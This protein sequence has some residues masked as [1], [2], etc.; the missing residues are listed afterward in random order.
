MINENENG[1]TVGKMQL[2]VM[3]WGCIC[4]WKYRDNDNY[5]GDVEVEMAPT[6]YRFNYFDSNVLPFTFRV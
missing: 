5:Y 4:R 6:A 3:M 2:E 1:S